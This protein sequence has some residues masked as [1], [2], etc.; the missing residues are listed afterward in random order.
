MAVIRSENNCFRKTTIS[1]RGVH[2]HFYSITD[3][4]V[5]MLPLFRKKQTILYN[6]FLSV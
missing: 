3:G 2:V 6:G 4:F 5:I 1:L